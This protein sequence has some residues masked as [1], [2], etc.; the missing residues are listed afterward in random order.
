MRHPLHL[1]AALAAFAS[2]LHAQTAP[3]A[4]AKFEVASVK[5]CTEI[6]AGRSGGGDSS[7]PARL[8][9]NCATLKGLIQQ[10]YIVYAGGHAN[11]IMSMRLTPVEGGPGWVGS[12]RYTINAKAEGQPDQATMKGPMLAALLED[13]FQLKVPRESRQL[14]VYA[15]TAARNGPKLKPAEAGACTPNEFFHPSGAPGRPAPLAPGQKPRCIGPRLGNDG[16]NRTLEIQAVSLAEFCQ[17][18]SADGPVLFGLDRPVVDKTGIAGKFDILLEVARS[19]GA[20]GSRGG[21]SGGADAAGTTLP[22]PD[23]P[24]IFV[25]LSQQL[26]LRLAPARGAGEFLVID[27]AERPSEN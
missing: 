11:P 15:L 13:R 23:G 18:L 26:G 25:A 19:Q 7:S 24:T 21:D 12:E 4:A 8:N 1:A 14:P 3:A 22:E 20:P 27:H 16:S 9:L 6:S 17:L 5:R 2:P 10:A